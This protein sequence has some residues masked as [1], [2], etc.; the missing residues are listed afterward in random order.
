VLGAFTTTL[1][2]RANATYQATYEDKLMQAQYLALQG[3]M[4]G[5]LLCVQPEKSHCVCKNNQLCFEPKLVLF[6][7]DLKHNITL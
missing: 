2:G 7:P 3:K 6:Y 1:L 5:G 4:H